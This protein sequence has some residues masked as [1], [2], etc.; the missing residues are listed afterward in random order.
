MF[1][2]DIDRNNCAGRLKDIVKQNKNEKFVCWENSRKVQN[3]VL[4]KMVAITDFYVWEVLIREY[5][6]LQRY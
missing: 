1:N 5:L 6:W 4:R 3:S 2:R